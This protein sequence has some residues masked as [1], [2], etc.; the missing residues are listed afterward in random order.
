MRHFV[1]LVVGILEV[2]TFGIEID[3]A[4][5]EVDVGSKASFENLGVE[6]SSFGEILLVGIL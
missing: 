3:E 1:E 6:R 4:I 5:C 2:G